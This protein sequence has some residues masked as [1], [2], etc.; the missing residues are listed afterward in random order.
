MPAAPAVSHLTLDARCR[1]LRRRLGPVAW[2]VLEDLALDA[3]MS[4]DG[5]MV[6]ATTVRRLA[7]NVGLNKDTAARAV[8]R[9]I[10]AGLLRRDPA[11][12]GYVLR[13]ESAALLM[14]CL[15]ACPT[16]SDSPLVGGPSPTNSD[17]AAPLDLP[18]PTDGPSRQSHRADQVATREPAEPTPA[19]PLRGRQRP[20]VPDSGQLGLFGSLSGS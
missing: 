9:L 3:E 15:C 20:G 7:T 16:S 14:R 17:S 2:I 8:A 11:A 10:A 4:V 6:A 13:P 1:T 19:R 18:S 12:R 5:E